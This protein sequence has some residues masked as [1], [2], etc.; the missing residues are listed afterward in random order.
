MKAKTSER[1]VIVSSHILDFLQPISDISYFLKDGSVIKVE[2]K[3]DLEKK[4]REL[5]LGEKANE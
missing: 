5:Y 1:T 3:I 4:Y 2:K